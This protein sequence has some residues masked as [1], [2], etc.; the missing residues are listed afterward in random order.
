M[1]VLSE[2]KPNTLGMF[3]HV[4][5]QSE[6]STIPSSLKGKAK[7]TA[8]ANA[9]Q[10]K[11]TTSINIS[12][13]DA[14]VHYNSHQFSTKENSNLIYAEL[15]K[16]IKATLDRFKYL[17][18]ND[19]L[20][21]AT[22]AQTNFTSKN[23]EFINEF[24][25]FIMG[26]NSAYNKSKLGALNAKFVE[27]KKAYAD[28]TQSI[29]SLGK[30][31][32]DFKI[33]DEEFTKATD[34]LNKLLAP[35]NVNLSDRAKN[36]LRA[37]SKFDAQITQLKS[38]ASKHGGLDNVISNVEKFKSKT[39][40]S[41]KQI[42]DYNQNK[43]N[44]NSAKINSKMNDVSQRLSN[45]ISV[46]INELSAITARNKKDAK[47]GA[48]QSACTDLKQKLEPFMDSKA[49][50]KKELSSQIKKIQDKANQGIQ[51]LKT[52]ISNVDDNSVNAQIDGVIAKIIGAKN[53][54]DFFNKFY[55]DYAGSLDK[56]VENMMSVKP[57]SKGEFAFHF[58][59]QFLPNIVTLK[60]QQ[61][62]LA[63]PL[64]LSN[65]HAVA[66]NG[67]KASYKFSYQPILI[68]NFLTKQL[69]QDLD[70]QTKKTG[71]NLYDRTFNLNNK[72]KT[73]KPLFVNMDNLVGYNLQQNRQTAVVIFTAS[74]IEDF[75]MALKLKEQDLN[76]VGIFNDVDKLTGS[77]EVATKL[78]E[79]SKKIPVLHTQTQSAYNAVVSDMLSTLNKS[80][81][82]YGDMQINDKQVSVNKTEILNWLNTKFGSS[83]I[84]TVIS[85]HDYH[86]N[87]ASW[88]DKD[89]EGSKA[90]LERAKY[91]GKD[92]SFK[93][94]QI[95][96]SRGADSSSP[97]R[98]EMFPSLDGAHGCNYGSKT[99]DEFETAT[100]KLNKKLNVGIDLKKDKDKILVIHSGDSVHD[101]F[102]CLV[103][104]LTSKGVN[105]IGLLNKSNIEHKTVEKELAR[106]NGKKYPMVY[107][108][109]MSSFGNFGSLILECV[110]EHNKTAVQNKIAE[111]QIKQREQA[112]KN[113]N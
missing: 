59:N 61:D 84:E 3:Y 113:Q 12:G 58:K 46:V 36:I 18:K 45:E 77:T 31:S 38:I 20:E 6:I 21:D 65:L 27:F 101:D 44:P 8:Q 68:G 15:A 92:K 53:A 35:A 55:T 78:E 26:E 17:P 103:S 86:E 51:S 29:E 82:H 4:D 95:I 1:T 87:L 33:E 10:N 41:I 97:K 73:T 66:Q 49:Q 23:S 79:I 5:N 98:I 111:T 48:I 60:K 19:I 75:D 64:S 85:S 76:L 11:L 108:E 43:N 67:D 96:V 32:E 71:V 14:V 63:I 50:D 22:T 72:D 81:Y 70:A 99:A 93:H 39:T 54:D 109:K 91:N 89:Y 104:D 16:S 74:K 80:S 62:N 47:L 2:I 69:N 88:E 28:V 56:V 57:F 9:W 112:G 25:A 102:L 13:L 107:V 100:K 40:E 83:K 7:K 110:D 106:F 42:L 94:Y 34:S 52:S 24:Q 37:Y 105:S 90:S 30:S